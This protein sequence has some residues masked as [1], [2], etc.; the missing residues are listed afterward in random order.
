M[1]DGSTAFDYAVSV[2]PGFGT[3]TQPVVWGGTC[4]RV[5]GDGKN[6]LAKREGRDDALSPDQAMRFRR[7]GAPDPK[8]AEDKPERLV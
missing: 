1:F 8:L 2:F 5:T 6:P 3:V 4:Y 7:A